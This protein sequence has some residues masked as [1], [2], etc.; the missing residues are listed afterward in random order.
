MHAIAAHRVTLSRFPDCR[1]AAR[2]RRSVTSA[3]FL[4]GVRI[5]PAAKLDAHRRARQLERV[6]EVALEVA[7]VGLGHM[8]ERV[9][10]D[11]DARR[12]DAALV[13]VAQLRAEAAAARRR[14]ALY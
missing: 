1:F 9:A 14:L 12:V 8:V 10:V 7:L 6:P 5:A 3:R 13:R 4:V 11:D 2:R